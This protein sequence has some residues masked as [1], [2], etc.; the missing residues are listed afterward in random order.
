MHIL[1]H[2]S[3]GDWKRE[4]SFLAVGSKEN[5]ERR[6]ISVLGL[7]TGIRSA[8]RCKTQWARE[9]GHEEAASPEGG[10]PPWKAGRWGELSVHLLT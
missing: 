2:F 9:C 10:R 6:P 4:R 7:K 8:V 3:K 5:L 1:C